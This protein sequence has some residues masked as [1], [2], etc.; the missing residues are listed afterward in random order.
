VMGRHFIFFGH[1]GTSGSSAVRVLWQLPRR[2]YKYKAPPPV[3]KQIMA[4]P[5]SPLTG[6]SPT[7][8]REDKTAQNST[9]ELST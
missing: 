5:R 8:F 3:P 6:R 1:L 4:L 9:Y 2:N 7:V